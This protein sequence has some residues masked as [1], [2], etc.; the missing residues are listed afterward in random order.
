[1]LPPHRKHRPAGLAPPTARPHSTAAADWRRH[2]RRHHRKHAGRITTDAAFIRDAFEQVLARRVTE[3]EL[4]RCVTF[5]TQQRDLFTSTPEDALKGTAAEGIT[6]A[7]A[8]STLRARESLIRVLF[9]H[10]DFVTVR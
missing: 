8:D 10:H 6:P 3:A 4:D 2:C 9:S 1:M 5:L 7:S